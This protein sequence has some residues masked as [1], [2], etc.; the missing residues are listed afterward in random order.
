M[1]SPASRRRRSQSWASASPRKQIVHGIQR[2]PFRNL[3]PVLDNLESTGAV[4]LVRY[5]GKIFDDDE[6]CL[7]VED[8]ILLGQV[9]QETDDVFGLGRCS[10][11]FRRVRVQNERLIREDSF[12][13]QG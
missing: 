7:G 4:I 13:H 9:I 2:V 3:E 8:G 11:N 6:D 10:E 1:K 5:L 12:P